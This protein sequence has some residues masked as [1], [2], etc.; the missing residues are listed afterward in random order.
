MEITNYASFLHDYN[1]RIKILEPNL[2]LAKQTN[3]ITRSYN[4]TLELE[5][6]NTNIN[7][8][9]SQCKIMLKNRI[10]LKA[11]EQYLYLN[12]DINPRDFIKKKE[13]IMIK[14]LDDNQLLL[15]LSINE[16]SK[17]E[18]KLDDIYLEW[19]DK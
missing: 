6:I 19:N 2:L 12:L 7:F 3:D 15:S 1:N 8:R 9:K 18:K 14:L 16:I 10:L 13:F 17:L 4:I 11:K 5:R